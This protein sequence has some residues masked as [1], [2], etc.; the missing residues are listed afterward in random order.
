MQ[1][2][3]KLASGD[4]GKALKRFKNFAMTCLPIS[5]TKLGTFSTMISALLTSGKLEILILCLLFIENVV[6]IGDAAHLAV[7]FTSAGTTIFLT[8]KL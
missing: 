3:V 7:P 2:D 1:Y 4:E 8:L 5:P 6:L